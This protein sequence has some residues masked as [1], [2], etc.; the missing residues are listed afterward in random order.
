[1]DHKH[2]EKQIIYP[3]NTMNFFAGPQFI[4]DCIKN[5]TFGVPLMWQYQSGQYLP[6]WHPWENISDFYVSNRE[7]GGCREIVPFE[8]TWLVRTFGEVSEAGSSI[9]STGRLGVDIDDFYAITLKHDCGVVGQLLV[10]VLNRFPTRRF[11]VT[12][13]EGTIVWDDGDKLVKC[14]DTS[15]G[16]WTYTTMVWVLQRKVTSIPK[17][18]MRKKLMIFCEWLLV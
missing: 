15:S 14:Y 12:C 10:D 9:G 13:S 18:P 5:Q 1:M 4:Q 2:L 11:T 3:S 7:T 17:S 16:E 6:D 8:L